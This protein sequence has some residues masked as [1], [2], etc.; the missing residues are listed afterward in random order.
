M[1]V[2]ILHYRQIPGYPMVVAANRD[3]SRDRPSDPPR[4]WP[5]GFLAPRD[6]LAG[7]TWIGLNRHGVL[8]GITNRS[9][10]PADPSRPTR[11]A[12]VAEALT[13][14]TARA[15]VVRVERTAFSSP[16][17]PFNLL[18]ADGRDAFLLVG[19]DSI[20]VQPL[21]AGTHVLSN[22]HEL[23]E[24]DLG[25]LTP[26]SEIDPALDRLRVICQDHGEH[27]YAVCKHGDRYGTVSSVLI[28]VGDG[29]E[30]PHR[31]AFADG[32]P[33]EKPHV[34]LADAVTALGA[35]S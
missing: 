12:L 8:A 21:P 25:D 34:E 29:L 15:A 6:R 18:V 19:G 4:V 3:E 23:G 1:C 5:Q 9:A 2:L 30:H 7:G 17:K 35:K 10:E 22:R 33:C 27:G 26:P 24:L 13:G 11:G 32:L 31:F 14:P 28:A 16:Q 20:H